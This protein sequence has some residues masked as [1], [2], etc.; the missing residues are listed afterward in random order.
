MKN[1]ISFEKFNAGLDLEPII[2]S[3]TQR[4]DGPG[5]SINKCRLIEKGYRR[6]LY[7]VKLYPGNNLVPTKDIDIFW[8]THILDTQKYMEDCD[9]ILGYYFHHFPY[10]GMRGNDDQKNL[11][12]AVRKT[13]L[14]Y[15]KHFGELQESLNMADC[16]ALCTEPSPKPCFPEIEAWR[17][18]YLEA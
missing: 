12:R 1:S 2:F 18:P 8:H 17:R 14:L 15:I 5:W 6:F 3:L 13:E 11:Q 7:L 9:R 16:G 4:G 10:F